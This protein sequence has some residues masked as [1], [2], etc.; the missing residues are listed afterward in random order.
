VERRDEV[1][2]AGFARLGAALTAAATLDPAILCEVLIEQSLPRTG[3]H[4]DTAILCAFL[5]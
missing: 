2:D 1:I 3:R 5:A 4:D